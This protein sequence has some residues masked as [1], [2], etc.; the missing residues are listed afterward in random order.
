MAIGSINRT[1]FAA[2]MKQIYPQKRVELIFYK[3]H[4]FLA[5]VSKREDFYGYNAIGGIDS[6][7]AIAVSSII[8]T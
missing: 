6:T 2:A 4:P 1:N 5:K 8:A 7:M 3:N